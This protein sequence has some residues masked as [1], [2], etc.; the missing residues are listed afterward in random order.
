MEKNSILNDLCAGLH[1]ALQTTSCLQSCS[2]AVC[3]HVTNFILY[4]DVM[5]L[6]MLATV[7]ATLE[8]T[9]DNW[10]TEVSASGKSSFIK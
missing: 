4:M 2:L 10:A 1:P 3:A 9:P 5:A 8:L 7:A 6:F